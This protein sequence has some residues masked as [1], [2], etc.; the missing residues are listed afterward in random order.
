MLIVSFLHQRGH[1]LVFGVQLGLQLACLSDG[2]VPVCRFQIST[3]L[4]RSCWP[5]V[6]LPCGLKLHDLDLRHVHPTDDLFHLSVG[7][8]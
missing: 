8:T 5:T 7:L 2:V 4:P 1:V 3:L 6:S